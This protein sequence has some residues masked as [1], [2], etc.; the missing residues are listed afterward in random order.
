MVSE[1]HKLPMFCGQKSRVKTIKASSGF[2][3][4]SQRSVVI[5]N[6]TMFPHICNLNAPNV[7]INI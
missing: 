7:R 4:A 6:F 2:G 1:E 3:L 5:F